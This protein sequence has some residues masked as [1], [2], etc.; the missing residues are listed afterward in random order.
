MPSSNRG[1]SMTDETDQQQ[2]VSMP[3]FDTLL[4]ENRNSVR[5]SSDVYNTSDDNEFKTF[6]FHSSNAIGKG[7]L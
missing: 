7:S 6:Y 1:P 2:S 5:E 3:S 4:L